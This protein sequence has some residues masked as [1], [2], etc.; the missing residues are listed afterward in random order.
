MFSLKNRHNIKSSG[1]MM[2]VLMPTLAITQ[3]KVR[4]D[5]RFYLERTVENDRGKFPSVIPLCC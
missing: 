5:K 4:A 1:N 2:A 3:M